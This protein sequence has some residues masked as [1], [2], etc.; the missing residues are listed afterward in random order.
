MVLCATLLRLSCYPRGGLGTQAGFRCPL[1]SLSLY[2]PYLNVS[3]FSPGHWKVPSAIPSSRL[4]TVS[5]L[6]KGAGLC[7]SSH[8]FPFQALPDKR[9]SHRQLAGAKLTRKSPT[10]VAMTGNNVG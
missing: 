10:E 3:L 5:S 4:T 7:P 6:S 2:C 1:L 8:W 9:P